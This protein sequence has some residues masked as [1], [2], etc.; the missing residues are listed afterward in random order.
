MGDS[1]VRIGSWA[2]IAAAALALAGCAPPGSA[3]TGSPSATTP[4]PVETSTAPPPTLSDSPTQ[5]PTPT[6]TAPAM[7]LDDPAT[8]V[9]TADSVGPFRVGGDFAEIPKTM[10]EHGWKQGCGQEGD[11]QAATVLF[12]PSGE[13]AA[14]DLVVAARY[15]EATG[16]RFADI[17][18]IE[19][20][21]QASGSPRSDDGIALGTALD[22]VKKLR[23]GAV[24]VEYGQGFHGVVDGT[25]DVRTYFGV[26]QS[27][28][29]ED[30]TL[31]AQTRPP[32]EFCA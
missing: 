12:G 32:M 23:P 17:G 5:A 10:V 20:G 4:P 9:I 31:T 21:G 28:A 30:I 25:G 7:D 11:G 1:R 19:L 3:P 13:G 16:D 26:R 15:D 8:W 2:I 18:T 29:I 24:D 6:D 27:D 22:E 14:V